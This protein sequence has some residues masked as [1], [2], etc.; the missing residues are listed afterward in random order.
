MHCKHL[1]EGTILPHV[2]SF[3]LVNK[4]K[5]SSGQSRSESRACTLANSGC[6]AAVHSCHLSGKPASLQPHCCQRWDLMGIT[7]ALMPG[8]QLVGTRGLGQLPQSPVEEKCWARYTPMLSHCS[9]TF[10]SWA[11][12]GRNTRKASGLSVGGTALLLLS[13]LLLSVP[14]LTSEKPLGL[15]FPTL[16]GVKEG[17]KM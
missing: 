13:S 14:E 16:L 3:Q 11:L 8:D 10:W 1:Q 2:L 12:D 9:R 17:Y 4:R 5:R 15:L 6:R 7:A